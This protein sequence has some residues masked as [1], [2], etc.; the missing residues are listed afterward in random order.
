MQPE[1]ITIIAILCLILGL[2]WWSASTGRRRALEHQRLLLDRLP[3]GCLGLDPAHRVLHINPQLH[4]MLGIPPASLRGTRLRDLPAPWGAALDQY[5]MAPGEATQE[6]DLA[7]RKISLHKSR[8]SNQSQMPIVILLEDRT[9]SVSMSQKL[10]HQDRLASL[11]QL[12][13]GVAHEIGN[14]LTGIDSLAQLLPHS[15]SDSRE[16]I[17]EQVGRINKIIR[18]LLKF[19]R[20]G[21]TQPLLQSI[22]SVELVDDALRLF[23]L[24]PI[25]ADTQI[26]VRRN[27]KRQLKVDPVAL[28]QVLINL[29][30]NSVQAMPEGRL[31]LQIDSFEN[32]DGLLQID[33]QDNGEGVPAE[34]L[35]R[36]F[37]PFVSGHLD[38]GGTGLG[39]SICYG[40]VRQHSGQISV[41]S[42]INHNGGTKMTITLPIHKV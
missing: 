27:I 13:A 34:L 6:V 18:S 32:G 42:P 25:A 38:D 10:A 36:I 29:F 21:E 17:R 24:D 2:V 28:T 1:S 40:I 16:L 23:R 3:M 39:L 37:E 30:K 5:L 41:E 20:E 19:S 14:P 8:L 7:W 33:V 22:N 4:R 12:A 31:V 35:P 11:G 26:D 9:D 15:E